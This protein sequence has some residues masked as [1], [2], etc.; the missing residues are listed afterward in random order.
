[1]FYRRQEKSQ[2]KTEHVYVTTEC[3]HSL[4]RHHIKSHYKL[5]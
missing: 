2:C 1:M 5:T 3:F 4:A